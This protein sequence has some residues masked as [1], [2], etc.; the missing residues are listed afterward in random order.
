MESNTEARQDSPH[1]GAA[2]QELE[3]IVSRLEAQPDL[4]LE[5]ALGL[6]ER[7]AALAN[8]CRTLL[9]A[10]ELRVSQLAVGERGRG[11]A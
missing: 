4:E 8:R 1:F 3:D 2:L 6:Y 10:A 9:A 11:A 5:E 7:G